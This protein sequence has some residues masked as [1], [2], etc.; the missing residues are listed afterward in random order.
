VSY[1]GDYQD[2]I[3]AEISDADEASVRAEEAWRVQRG[4]I[5]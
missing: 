4:L 5:A 3:D 2:E 1:Y